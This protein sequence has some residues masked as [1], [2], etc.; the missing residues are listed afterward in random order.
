MKVGDI[1]RLATGSDDGAAL[2]LRRDKTRRMS[3]DGSTSVMGH[4]RRD[5]VGLVTEVWTYPIY[6]YD[7]DFREDGCRCRVMV[8]DLHGW[9]NAKFLER[10]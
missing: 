1:V 4:M 8:G 3:S 6:T 10:L 2:P 9:V 7:P 5:N